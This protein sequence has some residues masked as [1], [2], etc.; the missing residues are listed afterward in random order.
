MSH[1]AI[2][3][4]PQQCREV[5]DRLKPFQRRTVD[6]VFQRLYRDGARRYLVADEVGLGKTLI[7]RGII[8]RAIRHLA[9]QGKERIDVIYICSNLTIASQNISRLNVLDDQ[10]FSL[11]SRLTLL[12]QDLSDLRANHINFVS[13]TP[14]TSFDLKS[15][16][17]RREERSLL[18]Q[19]LKDQWDDVTEIQLLNYL[20]ATITKYKRWRRQSRNTRG[21]DPYLAQCFLER[22]RAR[23][24][25]TDEIRRDCRTHFQRHD[26]ERKYKIRRR[27]NFAICELR[28]ILARVCVDALEPDLIIL[29]EFQR[30]RDLLHGDEDHAQLARE[31]MNHGDARV[32]LLSATPYKMMTVHDEEEDHYQDFLNTLRFLFG[33]QSTAPLKELKELL[34]RRRRYFYTNRHQQPS[35]SLQEV[36]DRVRALLQS[37][38]VRTERIDFTRDHNAMV[39]EPSLDLT[40]EAEDLQH[41]RFGEQIAQAIDAPKT[42]KYWKS[43]P[44][45]VNLM[46]GYKLKRVLRELMD[47]PP[48]RLARLLRD[49]DHLLHRQTFQQWRP[50]KWRNPRL[51]HLARHILDDHQLWK[52]LWI[53]ASLPYVI[54]PEGIDGA[55]RLT[56]SLIF[57]AWKV[58][59]DSIA[60]LLSYEAER[61]MVSPPEGRPQLNYADHAENLGQRL[62]FSTQSRNR[63]ALA[64]LYPSPT[65][66]ARVDPLRIAQQHGGGE[67]LPP[68][69]IHAH[70]RRLVA[71]MVD[72]V[73]PASSNGQTDYRW[74]AA[75]PA[76]ADDRA[77]PEM[78][79]WLPEGWKGAVESDRHTQE[80]FHDHLQELA[81]AVAAPEELGKAPGDLVDAL[82][83]IALG[84]PGPCALRALHRIAP[85]LPAGDPALMNAAATIAWSFRSLYNLAEVAALL[86]R[87]DSD[88]YWMQI[89]D[90]GLKMDL[91][92]V[93]DEYVHVLNDALGL[94]DSPPTR[95][96]A[97][98]ADAISDAVSIRPANLTVHDIRP[99]SDGSH[100]TLDHIKVRC[101][102]ALPFTRLKSDDDREVQR[103]STVRNG[104][105]SPFRPFVLAS[106][107]VGQE[108]LDF[109]PYAHRVWHWNLPHNPVD[110]EQREGRVHR[111][112]GHAI[113]KNLAAHYGLSATLKDQEPPTND[114]W[115]TL[116]RQATPDASDSP[117]LSPYWL[118]QPDTDDIS[119]IERLVPILPLSR[120][121]GK[122]K[123]LKRQLAVYRL[124]FGQARQEELVSYLGDHTDDLHDLVDRGRLSLCPPAELDGI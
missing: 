39:E 47:H 100:L 16:A 57:S 78:A 60:T 108:G 82:T 106:T 14:R 104:F 68:G 18:F 110:F 66:A 90:Y 6:F 75:A 85:D 95:R 72:D 56:K 25:L 88:A 24:E 61:R 99:S 7:A 3:F 87:G 76:L 4:S 40:I 115:L 10:A 89:A 50:I 12:P 19:L 49:D 44:Y 31:L 117:S 51:R 28:K 103:R 119:Q 70:A 43:A 36:T 96:V 124:A 62:Q 111:Y 48:K 101:R 98:I 33:D 59:P 27:R 83:T 92:A 93:L 30:F 86:D 113:R 109:H 9:Q 107:S 5:L 81:D 1:D 73:S 26:Q 84:A 63:A 67:P 11:S 42:L 52:R 69:Q 8:A 112:K 54:P 46:K 21:I 79:H 64:L 80:G 122:L 120:E 121:V 35:D 2:G 53:P 77:H 123:R 116:F 97:R 45:L 41:A 105:N 58:V 102:F 71:Q 20:Q 13:F 34:G 74:Y 32:L 23:P 91:Q 17:G 37:V 118:Y 94:Q 38:M 15:N 114:P 55:R 22:L 29:D 65:L